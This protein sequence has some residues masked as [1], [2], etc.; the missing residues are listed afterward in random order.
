MALSKAQ[1]RQRSE[2]WKKGGPIGGVG[3]VARYGR[4]RM[5]RIGLMGGRPTWQEALDKELALHPK[6]TLNGRRRRPRITR[7]ETG[8]ERAWALAAK[9]TSALQ[10]AKDATV[11]G[12]VEQP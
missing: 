2:A 9:A 6:A 11:P 7:K 5:G 1:L 8:Q 10:A 3:T 4:A 12:N